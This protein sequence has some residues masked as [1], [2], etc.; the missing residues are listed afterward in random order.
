M[1]N[2][3]L[4]CLAA[5]SLALSF[6]FERPADASVAVRA[7]SAPAVAEASLFPAELMAD[8]PPTGPENTAATAARD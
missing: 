3:L 6:F 4:Y 2:S 7:L 5:A 8:T 1:K